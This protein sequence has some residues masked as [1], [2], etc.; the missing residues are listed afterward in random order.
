MKAG[1]RLGRFELLELVARGGMGQ[2]WRAHAWD[3][4]VATVVA[5]K[6]LPDEY[7]RD[8]EFRRMFLDETRICRRLSHPNVVRVVDAGEA[9]A[10]PYVVFEWVDGTSLEELCRLAEEKGERVPLA[11]VLR[12]AAN[13][14]RGL[15]AAHELADDDGASLD[16]VHRD[17]KP[18][19]ILVAAGGDAKLI[20]F[21]I[22]YARE[23][24]AA[25]TR[26]GIVKGTPRYMSPEHAGGRRVDRRAD[27]WSLGAVVFRAL[28]GYPPFESGDALVAFYRGR[29][30]MPALPDGTPS[31][32]ADV[33]KRALAAR[34][35]GRF[36]TAEA[37]ADA[38]EAALVDPVV[39]A[40]PASAETTPTRTISVAPAPAA[41]PLPPQPPT[42]RGSRDA[43]ARR[44]LLAFALLA[45]VALVAALLGLVVAFGDR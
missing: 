8:D 16:V 19:N 31:K 40:A 10:V 20:D 4:G 13:V 38:L 1:A 7:A 42:T 5:V 43:A 34:V 25:R 21:G 9:G 12:I 28:A 44:R 30:P 45:A 39:A 35:E 41:A 2:V 36:P 23:R 3:D 33:V 14:A 29:A 17:V 32:V 37:L 22:V 18:A 11:S 24:A 6:T 27:V 15:H 26:T